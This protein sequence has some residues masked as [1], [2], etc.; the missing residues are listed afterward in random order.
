MSFVKYA[1]KIKLYLV[2]E[3][4]MT[5]V[6]LR[7]NSTKVEAVIDNSTN[8]SAVKSHKRLTG[9]IRIT[10]QPSFAQLNNWR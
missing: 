8:Y 4:E 9:L 2:N 7:E 5:A 3:M 6:T 10:R 1:N